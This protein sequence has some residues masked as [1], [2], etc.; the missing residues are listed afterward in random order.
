MSKLKTILDELKQVFGIK[1]ADSDL[2]KRKTEKKAKQSIVRIH[3]QKFDKPLDQLSKA[4][5]KLVF[6]DTNK[7]LHNIELELW[8]RD[9]GTPGDYLG[10]GVTDY[11]G[12][13]TIYYD[14]AK[15]G[16]LDKPD[17]ELRLLE[18]RISFDSDN[19]IVSTYR[20]AI[21]QVC[22]AGNVRGPSG[23]PQDA[24]VSAFGGFRQKTCVSK[25]IMIPF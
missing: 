16:F 4:T 9:I 18:N 10:V 24:I 2:G 12:E 3:E 17:L 1:L 19:D 7:P 15:A 8:D 22:I 13:F 23:S 11:N 25:D 5:G 21:H 6:G 20:I 14:P